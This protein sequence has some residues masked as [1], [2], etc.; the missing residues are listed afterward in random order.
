MGHKLKDG[1]LAVGYSWDIFC[2]QGLSPATE[3]EM[4]VRAGLMFSSD[5]GRHWV[6]GGDISARPAKLTP[7]AVNGIFSMIRGS[8]KAERKRVEETKRQRWNIFDCFCSIS[9]DKPPRLFYAELDEWPIRNQP[10]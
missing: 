7:H 5:G 8:S 9:L 4:E 2:E 3:G 1:R 10:G 6:A